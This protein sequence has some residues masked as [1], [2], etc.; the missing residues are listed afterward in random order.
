MSQN[1]E[2]VLERIRNGHVYA[3]TEA[4][5]QALLRRT[6]EIS[7]YNHTPPGEPGR[8]RCIPTCGNAAVVP[9]V[10]I[11]RGSVTRYGSVIGHARSPAPAASSAAT[12]RR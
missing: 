1:R 9:G 4:G 5:F 10:R 7:A 2:K 11:G 12:S 8:R 6:E 3:E